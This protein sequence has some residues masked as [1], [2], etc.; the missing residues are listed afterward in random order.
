MFLQPAFR[1]L[2]QH[3]KV[4]LLNKYIPRNSKGKLIYPLVTRGYTLW[5]TKADFRV[6]E[7][8]GDFSKPPC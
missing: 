4:A 1:G 3:L 6:S 8:E 5:L 7:E 2:T